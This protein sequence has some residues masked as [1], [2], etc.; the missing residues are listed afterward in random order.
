MGVLLLY[1]PA[2]FGLIYKFIFAN[3]L[4][5]E[6][7]IME[8]SYP[9]CLVSFVCIVIWLASVFTNPG[10]LD[11]KEILFDT[12]KNATEKLAL[13]EN[14]SKLAFNLDFCGNAGNQT[15]VEVTA[16]TT[17]LSISNAEYFKCFPEFLMW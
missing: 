17:K 15:I 14:N 5:P 2:M 3:H 11:T 13:L 12:S 7:Y 4:S 10:N 9:L 1:V 16:N 8:L 6:D